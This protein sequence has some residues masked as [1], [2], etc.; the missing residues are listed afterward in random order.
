MRTQPCDAGVTGT[1]AASW[2]ATPPTKY[3]AQGGHTLYGTDQSRG[4]L[5]VMRYAPVG[6]A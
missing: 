2:K 6:V 4:Y 3:C 5:R 1:L